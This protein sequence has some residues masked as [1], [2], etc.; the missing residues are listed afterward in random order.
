M[1]LEGEGKFIL[2]DGLM[3]VL[4]LDSAHSGGDPRPASRFYEGFQVY[5][6][7]THAAWASSQCLSSK[8]HWAL[9]R[10]PGSAGNLLGTAS[11]L[12]CQHGQ[13]GLGFRVYFEG[14]G[15]LLACHLLQS[16]WPHA[17]RA[18]AQA[19]TS[20]VRTACTRLRGMSAHA[21]SRC[22]R[23]TPRTAMTILRFDACFGRFVFMASAH[24]CMHAGGLR[25][26]YQCSVY[27]WVIGVGGDQWFI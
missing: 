4:K 24:F 3:D 22:C 5:S 7:A 9:R 25:M 11:L 12:I 27:T 23:R 1:V 26:L 20:T 17:R 18:G 14:L 8:V 21:H 16:T 6:L 19:R 15:W 13:A 2:R 10:A